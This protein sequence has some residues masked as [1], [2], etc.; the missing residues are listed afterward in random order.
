MPVF[1]FPQFEHEPFWNYLSRLN[2]YRAQLNQNFQKWKIYKVIVV[3]LNIETRRYEESLC[4]G[5]IIRLLS[6][7]QDKVWN[8]FEKLAYDI[9]EFNQAKKNFRYLTHSEFIFHANHSHQD[10]S[11]NSYDPYHS[12]VSPI[13]CDYCKSSNHAS[14]NCP[15]HA[16]VDATCA[17]VEKKI[18][19]LTDKMV[20]NMKQRIAEYSH[21]FS[22]SRADYRAP[23]SS[24]APPKPEVNLYDNFEPSYQFRSNL[25]DDMPLS[26]LE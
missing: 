8:F 15:Y 26:S 20:E 9:Y 19:E 16:Y 5:G 25:Q 13:F 21:C 24:L 12:Y 22:Q 1:N 2:D 11:M 4:L 18:N 23:N 3:G 7:T 17:S 14:C 6:R 10:Y